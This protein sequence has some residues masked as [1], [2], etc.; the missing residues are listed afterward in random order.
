MRKSFM[1][2]CIILAF[3]LMLLISVDFNT[4]NITAL[5]ILYLAF[6]SFIL[7]ALPIF[8]IKRRGVLIKLKEA[9]NTSFLF[10]K[11]CLTI[12]Y[13]GSALIFDFL[14]TDIFQDSV[15]YIPLYFYFI[16]LLIIVI[17]ILFYRTNETKSDY[18]I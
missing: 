9:T 13:V 15:Q 14:K 6:L 2:I 17:D 18:N 16:P 12:L 3:I 8:L 7:L 5:Q 11:I 1:A 4:G 10:V